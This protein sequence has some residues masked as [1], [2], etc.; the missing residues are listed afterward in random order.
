MSMWQSWYLM[1]KLSNLPA[2]FGSMFEPC[3]SCWE[4][5]LSSLLQLEGVMSL[6]FPGLIAWLLWYSSS[7]L[8]SGAV[9]E[10]CLEQLIS[11]GTKACLFQFVLGPSLHHAVTS[12]GK[13]YEGWSPPCSKE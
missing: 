6:P 11:W 5:S 1:P 3:C 12:H 8:I 13:L 7:G 2:C 9:Q 10:L 4:C